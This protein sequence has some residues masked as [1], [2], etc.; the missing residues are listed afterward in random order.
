VL[1]AIPQ[2][3]ADQALLQVPAPVLRENARAT[4]EYGSALVMQQASVLG[5]AI[6]PVADHP[7]LCFRGKI[8]NFP[9]KALRV[10]PIDQ[11]EVQG[12][13]D[14]EYRNSVRLHRMS[15]FMDVITITGE[16]SSRPKPNA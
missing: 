9:F 6:L 7:P 3:D 13:M 16:E 11:I 4:K 2:A 1:P 5:G 10:Q 15:I 14:T 8:A 12:R